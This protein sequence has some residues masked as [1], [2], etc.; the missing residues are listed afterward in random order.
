M[1]ASGSDTVDI[2]VSRDTHKE[3][4]TV[5][6]LAIRGL[7]DAYLEFNTTFADYLTATA[8]KRFDRPIQ[9]VM[10]ALD[11][12]DLFSEVDAAKNSSGVDGI[13]FFYVNPSAFSCI[14]SEYGANSLVSQIS[15]RVVSD[16]EYALT[17]FGGVIFTHANRTDINTITDMKGKSIAAAS[18]SGLGSGQM[19]FRLISNTVC[20][21]FKIQSSLFLPPTKERL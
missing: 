13:D 7:D 21:T 11:F 1:W 2:V 4:Y 5:G 9:F 19:Q 3:V 17:M 16:V 8:G 18:I 20:P 10:Q 15:S 14:E 12:L 6:V